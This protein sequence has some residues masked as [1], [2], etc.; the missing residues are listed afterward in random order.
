MSRETLLE[1]LYAL[2]KERKKV[3]RQLL[4]LDVTQRELLAR[5]QQLDD[6]FRQASQQLRDL[7]RERGTS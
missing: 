3:A 1:K 5:Q 4:K 2:G 6:D 7:N